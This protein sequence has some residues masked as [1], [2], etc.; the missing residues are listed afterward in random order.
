[1]KLPWYKRWRNWLKEHPWAIV[2][3]LASILGALLLWKST[4]NAV[5]SLDDAIQVR[6]AAREIAAKEARAAT[7]EEQAD[8]KGEN[9]TALR[10]E[11]AASK[12]RVME[13]HNAEPLDDKNDDEVAA[14]FTD[15]GF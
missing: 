9:V 15:A 7:L 8:A 12:R 14:L 13:I 5:G 6:A 4:G 1:M 2:V 3:A 10:R 11:V